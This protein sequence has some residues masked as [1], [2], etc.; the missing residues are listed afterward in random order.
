VDATSQ[1]YENENAAWFALA[2]ICWPIL[3][4]V[5]WKC[6]TD[7]N[8]MKEKSVIT[9]VH[10]RKELGMLE[11]ESSPSTPLIETEKSASNHGKGEDSSWCVS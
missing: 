6:T 8:Y 7:T 11:A 3:Y 5:A 9:P 2:T 10:V 4:F 1:P